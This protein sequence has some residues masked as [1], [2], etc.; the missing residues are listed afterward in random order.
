MLRCLTARCFTARCF[1][2][3]PFRHFTVLPFHCFTALMFH[4]SLLCRC[5]SLPKGSTPPLLYLNS[6]SNTTRSFLFSTPQLKSTHN[7][8]RAGYW[9]LATTTFPQ[10]Q[11]HRKLPA[12]YTRLCPSYRGGR[13][14]TSQWSPSTQLPKTP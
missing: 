10:A 4:F 13:V 8:P 6:N 3:S 1:T 12:F 7:A 5:C 9:Q 14:A 2:I 11:I